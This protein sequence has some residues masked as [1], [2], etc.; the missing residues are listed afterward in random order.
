MHIPAVHGTPAVVV[1]PLGMRVGQWACR[2]S[3][4]AAG[5]VVQRLLVQCAA[6]PDHL[7]WHVHTQRGGGGGTDR[8]RKRT[9]THARTHA[10]APCSQMHMQRK[11]TVTVKHY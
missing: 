7:I 8:G 9:H 3:G 6:A 10:S 1:G 2:A 5:P 11:C 4:H